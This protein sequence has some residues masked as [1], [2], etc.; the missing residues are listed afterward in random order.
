MEEESGA[1]QELDENYEDDNDSS[2]IEDED[3]LNN[4]IQKKSTDSPNQIDIDQLTRSQTEPTRFKSLN[5]YKR[6]NDINDIDIQSVEDDNQ[7]IIN[8]DTI[9]EDDMY[10]DIN[11]NT[12]NNKNKQQKK[13]KT[14]INIRYG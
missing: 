13:I 7:I 3:E 6:D 9:I 10:I 5:K 4:R 11:T 1:I 12:N 2:D 8:E 14:F